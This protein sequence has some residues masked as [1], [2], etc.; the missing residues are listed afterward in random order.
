MSGT[1]PAYDY[2]ERLPALTVSEIACMLAGFDPRAMT[3]VTDAAGDAIDLSEEIRLIT[4]AVRAGEIQLVPSESTSDLS[5]K[6]SVLRKS[7]VPW[8]WANEYEAAASGLCGNLQTLDENPHLDRS[9][10]N[11]VQPQEEEHAIIPG[12]LPR[13]GASR[14]AVEAAWE[15]ERASHRRPSA[16]AVMEQMGAWAESGDKHPDVLVGYD[17]AKRVI[18]WRTTASKEKHFD[19]EACSKAL[20]RWNQ[21]RS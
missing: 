6:S 1:S 10:D 5:P 7:L 20:Q 11:S 2:W 13:T 8:L 19:V 17:P 16:K 4:S 3:D 21:S 12:N 9:Q 18:T 14:V 15:L